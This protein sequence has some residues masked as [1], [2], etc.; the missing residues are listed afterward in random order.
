MVGAGRSENAQPITAPIVDA[1]VRKANNNIEGNNRPLIFRE[2]GGQTRSASTRTPISTK[3]LCNARLKACLPH[4]IVSAGDSLSS[5]AEI[6][7]VFTL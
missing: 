3:C 7:N 2:N 4:K 1:T 6:Q 5:G